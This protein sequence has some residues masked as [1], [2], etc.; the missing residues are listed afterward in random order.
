LKDGLLLPVG[1]AGRV[2]TFRE[3]AVDFWDFDKSEYLKS[4]KGRHPITRT[5]ARGSGHVV[6]VHL[7]DFIGDKKLD[8][9]SHTEIDKWLTGF[10]GR[11]YKAATGN[12][13]FA[14]LR[15]MLNRAVELDLIKSNP[16]NKVKK[17]KATN[18]RV[19]KILTVNECAK[20]FPR[21]WEKVW[22]EKLYYVINKLAFCT[23]MRHGELLGLRSE[24]VHDTYIDVCGQYGEF[25]YSD[26]K[27]HKSRNIPIPQELHDDLMGFARD[28]PHGYLFSLYNKDK[29]VSQETVRQYLYKALE[30]IG[31]DSDERKRRGLCTARGA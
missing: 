11:G 25:G 23:A 24:F 6:E 17:P 28:N 1:A 5:Y 7:L 22:D 30:R 31:I 27:T 10:V 20:L 8:E 3:F 26:T 14:L 15:T 9:I 13:V 4:R 16:C 18:K 2:P 21:E 29:P 19:I 12:K